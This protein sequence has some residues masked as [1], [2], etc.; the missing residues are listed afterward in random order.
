MAKDKAP[1][2]LSKKKV[3]ARGAEDSG[4]GKAK[5]ARARKVRRKC[6]REGLQKKNVEL[7]QF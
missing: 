2:E 3:S 7:M 1:G 4:K 5:T 6:T